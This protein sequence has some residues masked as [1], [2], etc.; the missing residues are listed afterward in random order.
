MAERPAFKFDPAL[1]DRLDDPDRELYLPA[2]RLVGE[3]GLRGGETVID[4]GAGTGRLTL[5]LAA[6]V[7]ESG[8]V[9]AVDESAPMIERLRVTVGGLP[10]V[11]PLLITGNQVPA[12]DDSAAGILAVN[13]LHEVRGEGALAEMHRLLAPGARVLVADWLPGAPERPGG[14]PDEQLYTAAE[15]TGELRRA[16]FTVCEADPLPYHYVLVATPASD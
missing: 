2:D 1:A 4:Y 11:E 9:L 8:R 5:P 7:G 16:G 6:A 13:L 12:E 14:P 3:L 15:A 10:S